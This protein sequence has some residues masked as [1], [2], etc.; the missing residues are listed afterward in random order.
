MKR[1]PRT[2]CR[3]PL[4]SRGVCGGS[5]EHSAQATVTPP[6]S[7]P[8]VRHTSQLLLEQRHIRFVEVRYCEDRL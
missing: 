8:E 4:R 7:K 2:T 6:T 3:Y 5:R 1:V